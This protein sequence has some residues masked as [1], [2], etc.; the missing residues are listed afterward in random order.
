MLRIIK[1]GMDVH[2][3]TY[4][5]CALEPKIGEEDH[6]L[7]STEVQA[8][9]KYI[10]LFIESLKIKLGPDNDYDIVCGYETG[11][12]GY[13]LYNRL[14]AAGVKC[15]ILA[16]TT[17]LTPQ[18]KR[19]KTDARDARMIAQCLGNGGYH[20]VYVPT[21]EDDAIKE[22][23]RMRD[24]QQDNLTRTKQQITAFCLRHGH[25]YPDGKWTIKHISWLRKLNLP[26][27]LREA[28]DEYMSAYDELTAKIER[29]DKRICEFA[30]ASKCILPCL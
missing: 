22:Y 18:G 8:D 21:D 6:L 12:L 11:C 15:V 5:L 1:I 17:M 30:L 7:A 27:V 19:V 10:L 26:G 14:T 28:L 3:K 2:S 24:D 9:P 23:I 29:F 20:A 4:T 13:S 16:P 25:H